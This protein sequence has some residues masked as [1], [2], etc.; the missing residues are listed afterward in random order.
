VE[1]RNA[2]AR[3]FFL[4]SFDTEV[5]LIYKKYNQKGIC[6][7]TATVSAK[8]WVVIPVELRRKFGIEPGDRVHIYDYGGVLTIIPAL[9]DPVSEAMGLFEGGASLTRA[10]LEERSNER[11]RD[12][13]RTN[14]LRS[15]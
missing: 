15:G 3:L 13:R 4:T 8:G 5:I 12:S 2:K 6:M 1:H 7:A 14:L 9:E 10:L 11:K